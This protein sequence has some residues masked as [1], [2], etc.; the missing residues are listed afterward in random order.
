MIPQRLIQAWWNKANSSGTDMMRWSDFLD[1]LTELKH[2]DTTA[3]TE[4][5]MSFDDL[6]EYAD[7]AAAILGGLAGG[8]FYRDSDGIVRQR[9]PDV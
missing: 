5:P 3:Y 4:N 7:D 6:P 2:T 8:E 9:L 1:V